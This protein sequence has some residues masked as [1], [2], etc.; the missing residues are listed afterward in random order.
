MTETA[1]SEPPARFTNT[2]AARMA[3]ARLDRLL[4]GGGSDAEI[5]RKVQTQVPE[6]WATL[7]QDI[8]CEEE[9]VKLTLRIDASVARFYRAMGKGYQARMNR[10]LATYAQMRIGE[11]ERERAMQDEV[12][13]LLRERL[14]DELG[15][16]WR[17]HREVFLAEGG[18]DLA[19]MDRIFDVKG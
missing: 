9:K 10:I 15:D 2:R 14:P 6:A 4:E 1:S 8:D 5:W 17:R 3:R 19:W 7:E 13:V 18:A 11:I 16:I 12:D